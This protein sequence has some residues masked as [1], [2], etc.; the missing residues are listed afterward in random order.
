MKKRFFG[1]IVAL[2]LVAIVSNGCYYDNEETLY[3][4]GACDT[5]VVKYSDQITKLFTN[6]C[7]EC[8]SNANSATAG[9]DSWEGYANISAFLSFSS[10]P[11]RF[12]D[13][14]NHSNGTLTPMPKNKPKLSECDI[15][16]FEI[17]IENGFPNN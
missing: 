9:C 2:V 4:Q 6:N 13:A 8:H 14:I 11:Q 15:R 16:T 5:A 17:W 1:V 10:G 12:I 7:Y 3:P